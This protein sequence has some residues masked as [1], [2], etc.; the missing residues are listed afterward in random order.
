MC[1][2]RTGDKDMKKGFTLI[3]VIGTI[4]I[5]SIIITIALPALLNILNKSQNN[6]DLS[7]QDLAKTAAARYVN[8][9]KND[10][11][12]QLKNSNSIKTYGN[13]GNIYISTLLEQGYIEQ[14]VY[15]KYCHIKND[16]I[17][18]TSNSQKYLYE[19]KQVDDNEEC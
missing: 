8:D 13:K 1:Y 10:F 7:V 19:Y 17:I 2:N 11:P 4:V 3:E 6:V 16:Y 5:L 15:D 9:R 14:D 18:V 12:K